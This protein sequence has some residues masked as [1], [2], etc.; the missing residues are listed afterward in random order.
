[1]TG[2][3]GGQIVAFFV[4]LATVVILGNVRPYAVS[5][6]RGRKKGRDKKPSVYAAGAVVNQT[7][8]AHASEDTD[9]RQLSLLRSLIVGLDNRTSTSK[10]VALAWTY[11]IAFGLLSLILA[12]LL[13]GAGGGYAALA[14]NGLGDQYW[15]FLGGPYA[16]VILAKAATNSQAQS[17]GKTQAQL[18]SANLRQL[19]A[20]DSGRADL[21]DFQY[22]VFNAIA[23]LFFL[24]GLVPHLTSG[25]PHMPSFLAG[26][27]TVS[28]GTYSAK[29]IALTEAPPTLASLF[30][31]S[32]PTDANRSPTQV[33]V[34]G[35]N[36][37][38]PADDGSPASSPSVLIAGLDAHIVSGQQTLGADRLKVQVPAG[39]SAGEVQVT[40]L[41]ADGTPAAAAGG[42]YLTLTL[43]PGT[44]TLE[45]LCPSPL[46]PSDGTPATIE[47][48]GR[49]LIIPAS[50]SGGAAQ[51]PTV[52][53]GG[54]E[55]K[56][57]NSDQ[58]LGVDHLTVQVPTGLSGKVN[59]A[60]I[61]DDGTPATAA[62][63]ADH[64][65]VDLT[66]A[67]QVAAGQ[68]AVTQTEPEATATEPEAAP[69]QGA[70]PEQV[71]A[72]ETS[73]ATGETALEHA[74]TDTASET[75]P[76]QATPEA[77]LS[78]G[79]QSDAAGAGA[80]G[81]SRGL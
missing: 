47:L 25:I 75:A 33:D 6:A 36:L 19:I 45:R 26:L 73:T 20:N 59:V 15:L 62:G 27:A 32:V 51:L 14:K 49:N 58:A 53:V 22:V 37:I 9:R 1:M 34:W 5:V 79:S 38:I 68:A 8:A 60:A 10:S 80:D 55:A 76:E 56:V 7:D 71:A 57:A 35:N 39:L 54:V 28:V 41:R 78:P 74:A 23:I 48:W 63:N 17:G 66:A 21:G 31:T 72:T 70:T 61:R 2:S 77:A 50:L 40:A 67:K 29:K 30:P 4:L 13:F 46:S 43:T 64:L 24:A 52:L 18:G 3:S 16:A 44:P 81:G 65:E 12:K 42:D 69:G 11:V